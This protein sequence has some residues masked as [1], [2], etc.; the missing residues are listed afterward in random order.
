MNS[1]ECTQVSYFSYYIVSTGYFC[2]LAE[3]AS[4]NFHLIESVKA[5]GISIIFLAGTCVSSSCRGYCKLRLD[6]FLGINQGDAK[7][8]ESA[9]ISQLIPSAVNVRSAVVCP[10]AYFSLLF[11]ALRWIL[12]QMLFMKGKNILVSNRNAWLYGS[13]I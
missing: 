6:L 3:L 11:H 10:F 5:S 2:L 8:E 1:C 9:I 12:C 4:S 7:C 13:C